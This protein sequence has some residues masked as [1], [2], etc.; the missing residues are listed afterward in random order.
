MLFVALKK[1]KWSWVYGH[2]HVAS[3]PE[4]CVT[5]HTQSPSY[6]T[7]ALTHSSSGV[8]GWDWYLGD[9]FMFIW[10]D[11]TVCDVSMSQDCAPVSPRSPC[12]RTCWRSCLGS[13]SSASSSQ[14]GPDPENL[15]SSFAPSG[16][17]WTLPGW[18]EGIMWVMRTWR[19]RA[20]STKNTTYIPLNTGR[21]TRDL[22]FLTNHYFSK[23]LIF[24]VLLHFLL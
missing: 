19:C 21:N 3:S 22:L 4:F 6:I 20:S 24:H 18:D 9:G 1:Q 5:L 2:I 14:P 11:P 16:I 8:R 13:S 10:T 15:V 12:S 23:T 17:S 7:P